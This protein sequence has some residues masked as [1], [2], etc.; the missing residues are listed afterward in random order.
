MTEAFNATVRG[1]QTAVQQEK[2]DWEKIGQQRQDMARTQAMLDSASLNVMFADRE[3]K[4]RYANTATLNTLKKFEHLLP[5]KADQIL[6][7]SIDIFHKRPEHPRRIV[8][9][10]KN[11]PYTAT[12]VLGPETLEL[13]ITP[14]FDQDRKYLGAMV[15]WN[16]ITEKL[17]LEKQVK[18]NAERDAAQAAE[19]RRKSTPSSA[20][21]TPCL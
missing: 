19:L 1:I 2:V 3:F 7:Q 6:G 11:L 17:A 15:T 14:V 18:E 21:S 12:I 4:I 13:N 10:P 16:V 5:I 20:P 8:S 9:D